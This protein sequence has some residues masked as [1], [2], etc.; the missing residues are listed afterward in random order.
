[1]KGRISLIPSIADVLFVTVFV[2]LLFSG[3]SLLTDGD[4][5]LHI[6]AGYVI[7]DTLSVPTHDMFSYISPPLPWTAHE[8]LS[9]VIM[10][11]LHGS[12]GLTGV[13]V[14][15]TIFISL[16]YFVLFKVIRTSGG[17]IL[18]ATAVTALV[19][20]SSNFHWLARPHI[21]SFLLVVV[22]YYLLDLYQYRATN[23][24]YLLPLLMLLWV[25]LHGGFILGFVLTGIY[26]VGNLL[27][28]FGSDEGERGRC[29]ERARGL[30]LISF[31]CLVAAL[32]NPITYHILLFPFD[33]ASDKV[34]M[35]SVS[36]FRSPDFHRF[37]FFKYL[38]YMMIAIF[39][40]S[41]TPL[42]P[43][44]VF[45][46]LFFLHMSLYSVRHVTIFAIIV[47]PIVVRQLDLLL[48]RR[49][50]RFSRFLKKRS[51]RFAAIDASVRGGVWPAVAVAAAL[52]FVPAA[53]V[54]Y[55]FGKDRKP[56]AAVE[57][58]KR[59]KIPGNVFNND[60]FGDYI[61][62]TAWPDY[63]V[64]FDGRS[65]MY[66]PE[67][68]KEYLEVVKVRPGLE[69]VFEKYDINWVIHPSGSPLSMF[70]LLRDDWSIIYSD[71]VTDIFLGDRPENG[72]L[73]EKY[74]GVRPVVFT[75][76]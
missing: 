66:G 65:D 76:G 45:L 67:R 51:E 70:L 37:M 1:M 57:F 39:A 59:E 49:D 9:E 46:V 47:A 31:A 16:V 35:D 53:G 69:A 75:E 73:L 8:W 63:K 15:F 74:K 56:V 23:R 60:E 13:V 32:A 50:G 41:R 17:N 48:E 2:R 29:R 19:I 5:G 30:A 3:E 26:L 21:F 27:G 4:T 64:F 12:F 36:E 43:I 25:N 6:R 14:F 22:W 34:L 33:M 58:L 10:A 7:L 54:E 38:L 18:A 42:K 44:E 68:I 24:L 55:G 52:V 20:V 71:G 28:A 61:I 11:L 40:V 62:Y 72:E